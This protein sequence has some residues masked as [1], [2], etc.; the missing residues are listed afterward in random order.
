[1]AGLFGNGRRNQLSN[2]ARFLTPPHRAR[3]ARGQA[4][5]HAAPVFPRLAGS[6]M[7]PLE[8]RLLMSA[9]RNVAGFT[10]GNL[11]LG[12]DR[13]TITAQ[14]LGFATSVNFFGSQYSSVF[15]NNNGNVTFGA[16]NSTFIDAGL[17]AIAARM[18]AP[19]YAD[20]DTHL[21]G[22]TVRYGRGT[23]D[24]HAAFGV[25]WVDVDFYSGGHTNH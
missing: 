2:D 6:G 11:G 8:N 15:V 16:R 25:N 4:R 19:F 3:T 12:D 13:S 1:M 5:R 24:G 14:S 23:V 20:V 22:S 10:T 21:S 18:L 9:V 7:E 17:N